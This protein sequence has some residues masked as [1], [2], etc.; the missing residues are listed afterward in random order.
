MCLSIKE[1]AELL[2]AKRDMIVYKRLKLIDNK[3][4]ELINDGDLFS[5]VINDINCNGKIHKTKAGELFFCTNNYLL[6]GSES[7]EKFGYKY[8]W[9]MRPSVTSIIINGVEFI[10]KLVSNT[11]LHTPYMGAN[12]IIGETYKSKLVVE[13]ANVENGLH[14]FHTVLATKSDYFVND[15]IV[16][17]I[18]PKGSKYYKGKYGNYVSYAS[19]TLKYVEIIERL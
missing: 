4:S 1:N 9:I 13:D 11:I 8:S 7:P 17:C 3:T 16:K 5:G 19:N 15:V 10:D 2:I 18:I 12:I 6:N 14:S